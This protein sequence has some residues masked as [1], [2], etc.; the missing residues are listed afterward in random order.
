MMSLPY[1]KK[2]GR[3][4]RGGREEEEGGREE[5][6]EKTLIL[7]DFRFC[8]FACISVAGGQ[9]FLFGLSKTQVM[10]PK[11]AAAVSEE[12]DVWDVLLNVSAPDFA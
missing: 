8:C 12:N 5:E 6:E 10:T 7:T 9:Y 1:S 2:K 3:R 4:G 11:S